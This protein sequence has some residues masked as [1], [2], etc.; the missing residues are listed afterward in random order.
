MDTHVL[1]NLEHVV[2]T[3][4]ASGKTR[5][6]NPRLHC[7]CHTHRGA[8]SQGEEAPVRSWETWVWAEMVIFAPGR[9]E[10]GRRESRIEE[11]RVEKQQPCAAH[12]VHMRL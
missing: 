4:T 1:H 2:A 9:E 8:G 5:G 11:E 12:R 10:E 6:R 7:R 3:R